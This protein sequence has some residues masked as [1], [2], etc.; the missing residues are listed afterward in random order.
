MHIASYLHRVWETDGAKVL[1]HGEHV[2]HLYNLTGGT[3][4]LAVAEG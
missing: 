3:T 1:N 4:E 2:V